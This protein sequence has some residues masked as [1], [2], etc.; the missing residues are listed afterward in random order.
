MHNVII[1]AC[2]KASATY[3]K[4]TNHNVGRKIIPGWNEH[5]KE[6][7]R[8]AKYWHDVWV[9]DGKKRGGDIAEKKRISRLQYHYAICFVKQE[10][11]KLKA[12]YKFLSLKIHI[13][14]CWK[15][16]ERN[17]NVFSFM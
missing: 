15:K 3:L 11:E 14:H 4:Y 5:V 16:D 7:A 10:K 9:R 8:E 13:I 6:Y 17:S 1:D 2:N 12:F